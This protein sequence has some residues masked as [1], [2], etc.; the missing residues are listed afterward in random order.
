[1]HRP[2]P[3]VRITTGSETSQEYHQ[4]C[5]GIDMAANQKSS[6]SGIHCSD[7][8]RIGTSTKNTRPNPNGTCPTKATSSLP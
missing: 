6:F 3:R 4:A 1:M 2:L 8:R 7:A 5:S